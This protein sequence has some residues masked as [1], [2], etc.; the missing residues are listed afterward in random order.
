MILQ[1]Q[2]PVEE[3]LVKEPVEPITYEDW[4]QHHEAEF[5]HEDVPP[6]HAEVDE[7]DN[8]NH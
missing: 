4:V 1:E 3:L 7:E 5:A 2:M 8:R 6:P